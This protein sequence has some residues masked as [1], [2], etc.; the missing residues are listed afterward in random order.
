MFDY[1]RQCRCTHPYRAYR[2]GREYLVSPVINDERLINGYESNRHSIDAR[3]AGWTILAAVA[4]GSNRSVGAHLAL[5]AFGPGQ[6]F[7]SRIATYAGPA[8]RALRPGRSH[9]T[10]VADAKAVTL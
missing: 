8:L 7:G 1:S 4:F 3:E 6:S 10:L 2:V 9:L 5:V